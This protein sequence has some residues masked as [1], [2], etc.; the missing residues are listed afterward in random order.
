[1]RSEAE[2][3]PAFGICG[4]VSEVTNR[5]IHEAEKAGIQLVSVFTQNVSGEIAISVLDKV[6]VSGIFLT[7]GDIAISL[8]RKAGAFGKEDAIVHALRKLKEKV[9]N[10]PV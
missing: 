3:P 5:Q 10:I 9:R 7:G 2:T 4:S 8:L 6:P 1:M